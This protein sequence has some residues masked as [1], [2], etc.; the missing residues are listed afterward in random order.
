MNTSE[1]RRKLIAA[2]RLN[3]PDERVPFAFSRRVMARIA[4]LP[5][6][7]EWALWARALWRSA[8]ACITLALFL[9]AA[10]LLSPPASESVDLSQAFEKTMLAAVDPENDYTR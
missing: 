10:S 1:L 2:A 7:D 9:G 3:A 5:A 8:G 6:L 4:A